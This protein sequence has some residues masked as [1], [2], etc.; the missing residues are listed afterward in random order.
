MY[1][2]AQKLAEQKFGRRGTYDPSTGGPFRQNNAIKATALSYSQDQ[3]DCIGEMAQYIYTTYGRFPAR[4]PTI[5]LRIYAQ[6]H[7]LE[8]EFYDRY[9]TDGAYLQTHAEHIETSYFDYYPLFSYVT[10]SDSNI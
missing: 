3:I 1:E 10:M 9:F 6:A 4:F 5:L 2:A 7:H 8:M